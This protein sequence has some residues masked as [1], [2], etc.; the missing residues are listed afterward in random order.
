MSTV[1]AVIVDIVRSRAAHDRAAS[2]AA[3]RDTFARV[4]EIVRPETPLW[5][6]VGDEFQVVYADTAA[7]L[8]ATTLVRTML[9]DVDCRFGIGAGEVRDVE[10]AASGHVIQDGSAWWHARDAITRLHAMQERGHPALR[11]WFHG[12][13]REQ[14]DLANAFLASRDHI[15]SRMKVR[16]R[17]IAARYFSGIAQTEIARDEKISQPAVSQTLARSGALDL[18]LALEALRG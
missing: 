6:T 12:D 9:P 1:A 18:G 10:R 15:L 13:D 5:A 14:Q 2:Q 7:S 3:V 4:D 11:T 16:E 8:H 17:R